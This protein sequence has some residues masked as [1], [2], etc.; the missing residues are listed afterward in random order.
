[1]GASRRTVHILRD[2][3]FTL[4]SA[5]PLQHITLRDS[6]FVKKL[7]ERQASWIDLMEKGWYGVFGYVIWA[8]GVFFSL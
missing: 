6:G 2:I 3:A 1:M 5:E 4:R 7:G 8:G